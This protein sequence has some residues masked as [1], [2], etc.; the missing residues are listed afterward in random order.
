MV[1]TL[2]V[3]VPAPVP[4][5][6]PVPVRAPVPVPVPLPRRHIEDLLEIATITPAVNQVEFHVGMGSAAA[7]ATD[8]RAWLRAQGIAYQ[9]F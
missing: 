6:V 2:P 1:L 8:D 5:P 4:V 7:N 3:P 9:S